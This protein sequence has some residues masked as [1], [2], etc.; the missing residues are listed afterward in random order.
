MS[1]MHSDRNAL[2]FVHFKFLMLFLCPCVR[3]GSAPCYLTSPSL[4]S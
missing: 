1:H 4:C 3:T 2:A